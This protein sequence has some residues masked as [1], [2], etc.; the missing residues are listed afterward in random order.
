MRQRYLAIGGLR[1]TRA[2]GVDAGAARRLIA[3][4]RIAGRPYGVCAHCRHRD[5]AYLLQPCH[6]REE[7]GRLECVDAAACERRIRL[8][9]ALVN[10][11]E[12]RASCNKFAPLLEL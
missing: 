8:A 12:R 6:E 1:H 3:F 11:C 5:R 4:W 7:W 2:N 10:F 9:R